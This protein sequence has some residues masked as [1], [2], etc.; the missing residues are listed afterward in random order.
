MRR[1]GTTPRPIL[2]AS[3]DPNDVFTFWAYHKQCGVRNRVE[4]FSDGEDVLRYLEIARLPLPA[5]MV[6]SLNMPRIGG[7]KV[8]EKLP[9][10]DQR[11]FP[12]VLLI[13]AKDHDVDLIATA[14]RFGAEAFLIRPISKKDFFSLMSRF[15]QTVT[16][17][18]CSQPLNTATAPNPQPPTAPR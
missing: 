7:L 16:L 5:L 14:Y 8:L 4:V 15:P 3:D 13:D 17:D 1:V 9:P 11:P 18:D 10:R 6:L 12:T 2:I